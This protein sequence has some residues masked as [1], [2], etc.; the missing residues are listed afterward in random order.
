[1]RVRGR[2]PNAEPP[3]TSP[4]KFWMTRRAILTKLM[5]GVWA[6]SRI[7]CLWASLPSKQMMWSS[8]IIG[9]RLAT[10]VSQSQFIS[11]KMRRSSYLKCYNS[12]RAKDRPCSKFYRM[13]TL[14]RSQFLK[15][16]PSRLL[17]VLQAQI[18]LENTGI[19]SNLPYLQAQPY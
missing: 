4:P 18:S 16:Y 15:L 19:S 3:T 8:L 6:S 7:L 12:I 2:R 17:P 9:L 13:P 1:M 5:Y 14:I 11:R 10:T